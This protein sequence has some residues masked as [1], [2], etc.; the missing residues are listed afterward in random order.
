M[1]TKNDRDPYELISALQKDIRRGNEESAMH[2]ALELCP[3]FE[4]WM[5]QRLIVIA[6]EDIGIANPEVMGLIPTMRDSY[7]EFRRKGRGSARLVLANAILLLARSPKSRLADHF[8]CAV[9]QDLLHGVRFPI[10]DYALDKHTRRGKQKGRGFDHFINVGT[11]LENKSILSDPY[12]ER[13]AGW[14]RSNEFID[15]KWKKL[16]GKKDSQDKADSEENS[17]TQTTLF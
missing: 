16:S 2:W 4:Y 17:P 6:H 15:D 3:Q 11:H 10:P 9:N 14:W 12:E 7:M 13:A 8:Q 1:K 5:W